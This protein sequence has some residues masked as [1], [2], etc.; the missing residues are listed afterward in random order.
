MK[1]CC[2]E[3][4]EISLHEHVIRTYAMLWTFQQSVTFLSSD[5]FLLL[6][7]KVQY[8]F[9]QTDDTKLLLLKF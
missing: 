5:L 8:F 3:A 1:D 4:K 7:G 9:K 6:T 2:K